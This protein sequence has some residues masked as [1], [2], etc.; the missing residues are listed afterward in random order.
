MVQAL[1]AKFLSHFIEKHS[2]SQEVKKTIKTWYAPI[3]E[4]IALHQNRT[5]Q[6]LVIGI[7]GCQGSGKSTLTDFLNQYLRMYF[8]LNVVSISLDD[9]YL[10][11]SA[12]G[13]ISLSLFE[14]C[15]ST[16]AHLTL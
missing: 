11:A 1:S 5:K 12:F 10:S 6:P 9:Y 7:N 14:K 15:V 16:L 4:Q 3:A 2:L 8:G 13:K